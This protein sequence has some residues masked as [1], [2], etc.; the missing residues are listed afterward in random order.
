M[1]QILSMVSTMKTGQNIEEAPPY[2]IRSSAH[3]DG[4]VEEVAGEAAD[5]GEKHYARRAVPPFKV[6]AEAAK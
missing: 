2:M 4:G 3:H 1:L 5:E 6:E